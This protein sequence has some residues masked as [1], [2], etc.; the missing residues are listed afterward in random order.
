MEIKPHS[1]FKNYGYNIND[2]NIYNIY[3]NKIVIQRLH[4]SGYAM[5]M[6]SDGKQQKTFMSHRFIWEC[7]NDIIPR[8]YEIDH[9]NKNKLDNKI[10]NLRCVTIEENRRFRDHTNI[11]KTAKIAHTLRRFIKSINIDTSEEICFRSKYQCGLY[12]C[13]SAALVYLIIEGLNR[14]KTAHT[15]KG[16]IKF[17]YVDEKDIKNLIIVSGK[18]PFKE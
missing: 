2:N 6:V 5:N 15:I 12:F 17:E 3:S 9:I 18:K 16:N 4:S 10:D 7:C 14:A 13:I 11:I 1:V 8:G